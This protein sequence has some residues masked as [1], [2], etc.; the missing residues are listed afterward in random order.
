MKL[1]ELYKSW[2]S[3]KD[4]KQSVAVRRLMQENIAIRYEL[5]QN[6][7]KM[8]NEQHYYLQSK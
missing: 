6:I 8:D 7:S 3:N 5:D 4:K 2:A 1:F